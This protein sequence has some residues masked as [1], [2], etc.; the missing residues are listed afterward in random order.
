MTTVQHIFSGEG[1]P[2][3][4]PG[5]LSAHYTDTLTGDQ[6]C[7]KG[8]ASTADWVLQEKGGAAVA[9]VLAHTEAADPHA[10]YTTEAESG[11]LAE[12]AAAAA[13]DAHELEADPH[14]QYE[15]KVAGKG[16]STNDYTTE[17]KQAVAALA[18]NGAVL[19]V[20]ESLTV[21]STHDGAHIVMTS[22]DP[23]NLTVAPQST[24][25]WSARSAMEIEKGGDGVI[26]VKAGAGVTVNV[27][28]SKMPEID[29]TFGV[30]RLKRTAENVWTLYGDL[31]AARVI[32][33]LEYVIGKFEVVELD[34]GTLT[35][36]SFD[37]TPFDVLP[38]KGTVSP[39]GRFVA[40]HTSV[41]ATNSAN[42]VVVIDMEANALHGATSG[43][44]SNS[45]YIFS[46]DSNYLFYVS[47]TWMGRWPLN[48]WNSANM[49]GVTTAVAQS[50]DISHDGKYL[51][52]GE[53][54]KLRIVTDNGGT[55]SAVQSS[56]TSAYNKPYFAAG[57][58]KY[59]NG[60]DISVLAVHDAS[61]PGAAGVSIPAITLP[62]SLL[63]LGFTA[64]S[65]GISTSLSPDLSKVYIQLG[66]NT[67]NG[68]GI[69]VD[70]ATG[71]I[72]HILRL[73]YFMSPRWSDDGSIFM[74]G[75]EIINVATGEVSKSLFPLAV[76]P[77]DGVMEK[78]FFGRNAVV[79]QPPAIAVAATL[80]DFETNPTS[81]QALATL[82][83]SIKKSG[84]SSL[85]VAF[86]P[87]DSG[88]TVEI[89]AVTG[90]MTLT[91]D[92]VI[93]V[94]IR[95]TEAD[96][97][98][99]AEVYRQSDDVLLAATWDVWDSSRMTA[100]GWVRVYFTEPSGS[101]IGYTNFTAGESVYFKFYSEHWSET[102]LTSGV[103]FDNLQLEV[104]APAA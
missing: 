90:P 22:A 26:T 35:W 55:L 59:V 44:S 16:L 97:Q 83:T 6:Y 21:D 41:T 65:K 24:G 31:A 101:A 99:K 45:H 38:T 19:H 15:Q 8:T 32:G 75:R 23:L 84:A 17:D 78:A 48:P 73:V 102:T 58:Y 93:G 14:A 68:T 79:T 62:Q 20:T 70:V 100:D 86:G 28:A 54:T 53:G 9:A 39:D 92:G 13:V 76:F 69:I 77:G 33:T 29:E 80:A 52:L 61:T 71:S 89:V 12:S 104:D 10:Q 46:P 57:T 30:G 88:N 4:V 7:A 82:D 94:D 63:D 43:S 85:K 25:G 50:V 18:A 91:V 96:G 3:E 64:T 74:T 72:L 40:I 51:L 36:R 34:W 42:R 95:T 1:A 49:I 5:S 11:A 60:T 87:A 98:G 56:Y 81:G 66:N 47:N 2:T 37:L 27:K 67:D 103:W